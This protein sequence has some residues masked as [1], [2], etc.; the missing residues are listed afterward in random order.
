M[1]MQ[2]LPTDKEIGKVHKHVWK[3]VCAAVKEIIEL[4]TE[5]TED[6]LAKR[7]AKP[8]YRA[9]DVELLK[10]PWKQA[11]Q[12]LVT[13]AMTQL[14]TQFS[15]RP[16]FFQ[17]NFVP[18][19]ATTAWQLFGYGANQGKH[20]KWE[21]LE[22]VVAIECINHVNRCRLDQVMWQ[23]IQAFFD[24][25]K[26]R[27]KV[28]KALSGAYWRAVEITREEME[29]QQGPFSWSR[30]QDPRQ[31]QLRVEMFVRRWIDD[32]TCRAWGAI[33][34]AGMELN[35]E[36][37]DGFFQAL[38][39]PFGLEDPF[40]CIPGELTENIGVPPPDWPFIPNVV[41]ELFD[42]WT[43]GSKKKRKKS[44]NGGG[45]WESTEAFA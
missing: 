3:G 31:D 37:L 1:M 24:D 38:V 13:K 14:A 25:E 29:Q 7:I 41:H 15:E 45:D 34:S 10:L 32:S 36:L 42:E 27:S 16:W 17:I 6:D 12:E 26:L 11:A 30:K 28:W 40:S 2:D 22:E 18:T 44:S 21:Q 35:E 33:E 8:I 19:L 23:T 5:R 4:E 43:S 9:V 39:S 20:I